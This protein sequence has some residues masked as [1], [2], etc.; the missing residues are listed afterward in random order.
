VKSRRCAQDGRLV[1]AGLIRLPGAPAIAGAGTR[2]KFDLTNGK[3]PPAM[4]PL[5]VELKDGLPPPPC[6][7]KRAERDEPRIMIL[8]A[9]RFR[10]FMILLGRDQ[11]RPTS[12]CAC[13][14][15]G[16]AAAD[17]ASTQFRVST[18]RA[19]GTLTSGADRARRMVDAVGMLEPIRR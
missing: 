1:S 7:P 18:C 8:R 5:A 3:A 15:S 13:G 19:A 17:S 2:H 14:L 9:Q 10:R 6:G 16:P 11:S 12:R 4:I